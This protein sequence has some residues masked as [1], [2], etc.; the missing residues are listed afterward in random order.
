MSSASL[1]IKNAQM[2]LFKQARV[3]GKIAFFRHTKLIIRERTSEDAT[4]LWRRSTEVTGAMDGSMPGRVGDR[5]ESCWCTER[6]G[7]RVGCCWCAE[8]VGAR[9][10]LCWCAGRVGTHDGRFWCC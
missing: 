9:F 8:K 3:E 5:D 2:L 6:V 1:A 4:G 10:E 7:S